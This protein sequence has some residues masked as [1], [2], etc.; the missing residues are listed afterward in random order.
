VNL[1]LFKRIDIDIDWC[2]SVV[3]VGFTAHK[4]GFHISLVFLDIS[5]YYFSPKRR[6]KIN[7]QL[8]DTMAKIEEDWDQA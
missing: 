6:A 2:F 4:R 7:E 1:T 8:K 3:S 5:A